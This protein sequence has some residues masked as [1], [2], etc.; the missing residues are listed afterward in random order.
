ME[1][2]GIKAGEAFVGI[3][4]FRAI[5]VHEPTIGGEKSRRMQ[6]VFIFGET[7]TP[8]DQFSPCFRPCPSECAI[9]AKAYDNKTLTILLID[10]F[11]HDDS[12]T[13]IRLRIYRFLS[14][15]RLIG[16]FRIRKKAKGVN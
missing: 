11:R 7:A 14:Y 8:G 10:Q 15:Y 16:F 12:I 9:C 5:T 2:A 3:Q 4:R 6:A 1:E 13:S